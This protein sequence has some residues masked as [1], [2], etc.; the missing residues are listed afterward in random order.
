MIVFLK[1]VLSVHNNLIL[2]TFAQDSSLKTLAIVRVC[3]LLIEW[4]YP[5][6]FISGKVKL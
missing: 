2:I 5:P 6:S 1:E 3:Y 4:Q